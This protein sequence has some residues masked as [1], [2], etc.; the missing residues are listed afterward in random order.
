M[1]L[2]QDA[3]LFR[4]SLGHAEPLY[5]MVTSKQRTVCSTPS[6]HSTSSSSCFEVQCGTLQR[7]MLQRTKATTNNFYQSNQDATTKVEEYY[8]P[9]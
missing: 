2:L 3:N 5:R 8:R 6:V 4:K 9:T 7:T 1:L